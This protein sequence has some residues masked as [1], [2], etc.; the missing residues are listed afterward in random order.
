MI[1]VDVRSRWPHSARDSGHQ[2]SPSVPRLGLFPSFPR[3]DDG[4]VQG[5]LGARPFM[6]GRPM[7]RP[8]PETYRPR[9]LRRVRLLSKQDQYVTLHP[10]LDEFGPATPGPFL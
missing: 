6:N 1:N 8:T 9:E 7:L 2:G 4:R 5:E 10:P 3:G